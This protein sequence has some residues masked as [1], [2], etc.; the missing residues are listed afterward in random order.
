MKLTEKEGKI[1]KEM[2]EERRYRGSL[3]YETYGGQ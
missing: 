2:L 1:S 3:I